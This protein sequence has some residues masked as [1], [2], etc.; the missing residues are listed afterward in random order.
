VVGAIVEDEPTQD[1]KDR[2]EALLKEYS[3]IGS[4][5][6]ALTEIRF[7]LLG[8][9]PLAALAAAAL[10]P[11]VKAPETLPFAVFGLAA[12]LCF[13]TYNKRNDQLYDGLIERAA[14]IE[15]EI[16]IPDGAFA[17][18]QTDW[19]SYGALSIRWPV[20][21]RSAISGV[22]LATAAFWLFLVFEVA[23]VSVH[24]DVS[25]V[26]SA[27]LAACLGKD[28]V[29]GIA[30]VMLALGAAVL[31]FAAGY[32]LKRQ[33]NCRSRSMKAALREAFEL[34]VEG[35][36]NMIR[37][38]T[39]GMTEGQLKVAWDSKG[40]TNG[41]FLNG[42]PIRLS[43]LCAR[44]M[45]NSRSRCKTVKEIQSRIGFYSELNAL[46]M[47]RYVTPS[48]GNMRA[49]QVLALLTD[50]P[51]TSIHDWSTGR[52]DGE[53]SEKIKYQPSSHSLRTGRIPRFYCT[54]HPQNCERL[55]CPRKG[56]L[57]A[58]KKV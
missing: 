30:R 32:L 3:E 35:E 29:G 36:K 47:Q 58:K 33:E 4:N 20:G 26:W 10:K 56:E 31:V 48:A 13:V 6:R 11:E 21:H 7:K 45:T 57:T 46:D 14:A 52:R 42:D 12:T 49:A 37:S 39:P 15:R 23:F 34:V 24:V 2:R 9:L 38:Q 40:V 1:Q 50:L 28:Q 25:N 27:W 51:P 16:G 5:F 19:L 17:H 44:A 18:R 43:Q 8:L 22:Y 41:N 55:L 54:G 53:G